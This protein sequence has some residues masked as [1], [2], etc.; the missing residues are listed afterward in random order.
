MNILLAFIQLVLIIIICIYEYK[1]KYISIFLWATLL[2]MFGLPHF[3]AVIT[4]NTL[5]S[6]DVMIKASIFVIL[7]NLLYLFTKFFIAKIKKRYLGYATANINDTNMCVKEI[8]NDIKNKYLTKLFFILLLF[9]FLILI[10]TSIMYLGSI[11]NCSWGNFR[12]L[13]A[14]LGF[15]NPIKYANCLF[16]GS[17]GIA[18]AYIKYNKKVIFLIS[19]GIIVS[20]VMITGNRITILP[21]LVA[22]IIPFVFNEKKKLPIKYILLFGFMAFFTIYLVYFLR[23]LRIYGGFYNLI[24]GYNFAQ[25]NERVFSMLLDGNGELSLRKAFYHFIDI[26][27]NW[28]NFNK[29]HTYIRL[30]LI[31]IPTSLSGGL[32]PFDFAITMGS[33]WSNNPYNT[34]YSMHPTLYGDCFA[35]LWWFGIFLGVFWAV[36]SYVLDKCI[37]R[38]NEVIKSMLMVLFG[39]VYVI[40]G[41]GSVYNGFFIGYA[42]SIVIG[43]T[44]LISRFKVKLR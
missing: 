7:F 8:N 2:V 5:Y 10:G 17:A 14:G 26:N 41:R 32:K 39:T 3:L 11:S 43:V 6:D 27:N 37:D 35:N 31:A 36:F 44:Y 33:A 13:S 9:S 19:L 4:N 15:R 18:L 30:L 23:L 16:F 25:I 28:P 1:K 40:A 21:A 22:I 12:G 42:G 34:T 20:Y 29:G 38:K 24:S